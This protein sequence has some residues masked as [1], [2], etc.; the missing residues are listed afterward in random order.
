M[1]NQNKGGRRVLHFIPSKRRFKLLLLLLSFF[2]DNEVTRAAGIN[3]TSR[4]IARTF[5]RGLNREKYNQTYF[6]KAKK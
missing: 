3:L 4:R 5:G 1:K 2:R 6:L